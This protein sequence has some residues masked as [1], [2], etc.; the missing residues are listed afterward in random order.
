MAIQDKFTDKIIVS[1][2]KALKVEHGWNEQLVSK[3]MELHN[4]NG[5]TN[6]QSLSNAFEEVVV[7]KEVEDND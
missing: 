7:S 4:S 2:L 3:I 5:L 6:L 1:T